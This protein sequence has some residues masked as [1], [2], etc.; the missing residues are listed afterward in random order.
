MLKWIYAEIKTG[1]RKLL[2]LSQA[3]MLRLENQI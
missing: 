1:P 3:G 2:L